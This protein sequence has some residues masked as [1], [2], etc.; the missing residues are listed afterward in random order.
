M[1]VGTGEIFRYIVIHP[2]KHDFKAKNPGALFAAL[3]RAKSARREDVV[4]DFAF[5]E[6]VLLN[7]DRFR[8]V[9]TPT[10]RA[11]AVEMKRHRVL[12]TQ[13]QER[14]IL[15]PAYRDRIFL[16]PVG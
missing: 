13:C 14:E 6:D 16:R 15:I 9:N 4:R 10:T 8:P 2:G 7:D 3:S 1:T 12:A 5:H 11:G